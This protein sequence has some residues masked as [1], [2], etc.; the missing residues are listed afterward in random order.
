MIYS[1]T[2]GM[3]SE[4]PP[5]ALRA[6]QT[7]GHGGPGEAP[8]LEAREQGPGCPREPVLASPAPR[9]RLADGTAGVAVLP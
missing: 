1:G 2:T 9:Q 8:A 4:R 7:S 5:P 3:A 6:G